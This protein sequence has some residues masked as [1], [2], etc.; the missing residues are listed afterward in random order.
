[1][2][3][4][5][6]HSDSEDEAFESADE[7]ELDSRPTQHE[8]GD[9]SATKDDDLAAKTEEKQQA[10]GSQ[11]MSKEKED[12]GCVTVDEGTSETLSKEKDE[13]TE[14]ER[15]GVEEGLSNDL[16]ADVKTG[17]KEEDNERVAENECKQ[18]SEEGKSEKNDIGTVD[19]VSSHQI[20]GPAE[21][22][23]EQIR[24]SAK[25]P[26]SQSPILQAMDRLAEA[27]PNNVSR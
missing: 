19:D 2:E 14:E 24:E 25:G 11:D 17:L 4:L 3:K 5:N 8:E 7:G 23:T 9:D 16:I 20:E 18:A 12:V 22:M 26:E 21:P 13:S 1:M 10:S 27:S 6:P 15:N